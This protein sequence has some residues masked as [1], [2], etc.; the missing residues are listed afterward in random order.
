M[1]VF[2]TLSSH[3][4]FDVPFDRIK[5]DKYLNSVAYTDSC[6]GAF[7]DRIKATPMWDNLLIIG[8]PDHCF[9]NCPR[10]IMVH[11]SLRYHSPM[12]W[13]GGAVAEPKIVD[14]YGSHI[15]LG[16]TLLAQLGIDHTAFSFSKDLADP[17][18]PHFAYYSWSDGFGF[19]NDSVQY[20]QDNA[21]DGHP[22]SGSND[23]YGVAQQRGKAYLQQLYDD[24][25]HR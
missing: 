3:E 20:I 21:N 9:S 19:L 10:G 17:K 1:K 6:L 18:T 11:E 8:L 7:I 16:A 14:T 23:P 15:D 22:L 24:L 2:L 5:E 4:P 13:T 12:F 25:S